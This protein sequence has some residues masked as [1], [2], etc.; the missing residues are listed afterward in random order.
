MPLY[1]FCGLHLLAA[2][3]RRADIDGSAG[4]VEETARIVAQI[5]VRWPEV[6]IVLRAD[7]GFAREALMSWCEANGVGYLFGLAKNERLAAEISTELAQRKPAIIFDR[8]IATLPLRP[9]RL[10]E[11]ATVTRH[12]LRAQSLWS[13]QFLLPV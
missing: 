13:P 10:A 9:P 7:S 5:R 2:K 1:I 11:V 4:A 6:R 12:N 8:P 3:L